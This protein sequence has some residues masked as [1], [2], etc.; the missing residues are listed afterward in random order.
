MLYKFQNLNKYGTLRTRIIHSPE[1]TPFSFN[2]KGFGKFVNVQAFRYEYKHEVLP[3]SL[4]T[5]QDG[6][7][8]IVPTWQ[9]VHPETRLKDIN[10]VKPKPKKRTA[11]LVETNIS[12]S[13]GSEYETKYY[14]DSGNYYCT[15]PGTWRAKDRKCKHIKALIEK[16]ND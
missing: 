4:F 12:S 16:I 14:P 2:P 10:W 5:D 9:K 11:P 7:K 6:Q 13:N 1:G 3:P 15:C 8:W